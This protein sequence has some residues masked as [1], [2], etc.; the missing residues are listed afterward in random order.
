MILLPAKNWGVN[1]NMKYELIVGGE[2]GDGDLETEYDYGL[3]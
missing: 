1:E 2:G 3:C